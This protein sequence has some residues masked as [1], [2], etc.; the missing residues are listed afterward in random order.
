MIDDYHFV[1]GRVECLLQRLRRSLPTCLDSSHLFPEE[2]DPD[3]QGLREVEVYLPGP[4]L[5]VRRPDVDDSLTE[6]HSVLI[7]RMQGD[8][9]E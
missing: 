9:V 4:A 3:K 1:Y 8:F 2:A 6:S 5:R 7:A